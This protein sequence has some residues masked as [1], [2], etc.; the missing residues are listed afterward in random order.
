MEDRAKADSGPPGRFKTLVLFRTFDRY[1]QPIFIIIQDTDDNLDQEAAEYLYNEST[2]P[3]NFLPAEAVMTLDDD[4]AHGAI[5][6]VR[7]VWMPI[8]YEGAA[9]KTEIL[10]KLFPETVG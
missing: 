1:N 6:F 9:D 2:C 4:D 8:E 5:E 10:R 3:T 7:S